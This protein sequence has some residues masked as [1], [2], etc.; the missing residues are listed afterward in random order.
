MMRTSPR[1]LVP[2]ALL[3]AW[4]GSLAIGCGAD[5]LSLDE[6]TSPA[7]LRA[8]F[9]DVADKVLTPRSNDVLARHDDGFVLRS[10]G[11]SVGTFRSL[12][13]DLPRFGEGTV[14]M[15]VDGGFSIEVHER[16]ALGE[17][18]EVELAIAYRR[19]GGTS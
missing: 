15:H 3:L 18:A 5:E 14:R 16:G 17:G 19:A 4:L 8:I 2:I 6:S 7:S 10:V 9:P 13:A 12:F 11:D 1:R